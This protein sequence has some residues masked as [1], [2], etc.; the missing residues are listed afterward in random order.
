MQREILGSAQDDGF[1]LVRDRSLQIDI[2]TWS[3]LE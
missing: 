1:T 2:A 3:V